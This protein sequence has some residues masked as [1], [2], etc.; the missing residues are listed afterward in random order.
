MFMLTVQGEHLY[1]KLVVGVSSYR[2]E[3]VN[4]AFYDK[5]IG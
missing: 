1:N 4:R 2:R 3:T 5:I